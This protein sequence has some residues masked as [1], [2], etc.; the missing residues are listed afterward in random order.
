MSRHTWQM[1]LGCWLLVACSSTFKPSGT[2]DAGGPDLAVPAAV[3]SLTKDGIT[4][5]FATPV[6]AGQFVTGDY[7]IVGPATVSAIDPAPT[8][9]SPYL[10]GSV[11][12]LPTAN[13]K[14]GF[15]SRLNAP[16]RRSV[17]Q[18]AMRSCRRAAWRRR[19]R[20]RGPC[21]RWT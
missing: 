19:A 11:L 2:A 12:N 15:D 17:S 3:S 13:G 20:C 14:S 7:Y 1:V 6:V 5:T 18:P 8:T 16:T 21:A 4:W 9:S 10:N